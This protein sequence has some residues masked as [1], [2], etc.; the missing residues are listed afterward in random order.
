[1]NENMFIW[2]TVGFDTAL[3]ITQTNEVFRLIQIILTCITA[4]VGLCYTIWKWYKKSKKDGK[5]TKDELSELVE[6]LINKG[7][8]EDDR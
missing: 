5:I 7:E 4:F 8:D 3:T 2:G 1:M 6:N